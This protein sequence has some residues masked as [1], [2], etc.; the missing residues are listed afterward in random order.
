MQKTYQIIVLGPG[1]VG[2]TKGTLMMMKIFNQLGF[3]TSEVKPWSE[4][5]VVTSNFVIHN[6]K[7]PKKYFPDH[8]LDLNL[9]V[10]DIGGQF[11]Y[12]TMWKDLAEDT[13]AIVVIVDTT[14]KNTLKQVP[15]MLP[16]GIMAGVPVRL[17][18]NKADLYG[19]FSNN[20]D[21]FAT[22]IHEGI[23]KAIA[24]EG[25]YYEVKYRGDKEFEFSG[26]K[27][28][29]GDM[30]EV[31]RPLERNS[32]R[33]LTIK[34]ADIEIIAARA[35]KEVLPS[36]SEHNCYLFGREFTLQLFDIVYSY[37][38]QTDSAL[39]DEVIELAHFEAP[40]FISW[41]Q[42]PQGNIPRID[43]IK[44]DAIREA[45]ENML[46][47]EKDIVDM[48]Q[49]LRK[50]GYNLDIND[51]RNWALSSCQIQEDDP[52]VTYKPINKAM[53]PPYFVRMMVDYGTKKDTERE[54]S[55]FV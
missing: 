16:K 32:L 3:R 17:I 13:D 31:V 37:I 23:R 22:T 49:K 2:K 5:L 36:L 41:G 15:L 12:K 33:E 25:V 39:T 24:D 26:K 40:P 1:G 45:V 43:H 34:L 9:S 20:A 7:I 47:T 46:I 28:K 4:D 30:I 29:Y 11:K 44:F 53:L 27:Y 21:D 10:Y 50:Q 38:N 8:D 51:D 14:R 54:E 18:V 6:I 35:F 42:D 19:E 55:Y 48:V 52:D